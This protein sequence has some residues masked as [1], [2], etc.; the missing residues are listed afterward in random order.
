MIHQNIS[1]IVSVHCYVGPYFQKREITPNTTPDTISDS[2][3]VTT[4][5]LRLNAVRALS[6]YLFKNVF[7]FGHRVRDFEGGIQ[8]QQNNFRF[9]CA[10]TKLYIS[11]LRNRR[12]IYL[13]KSLYKFEYT[14]YCSK[15]IK[16]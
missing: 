15:M 7:V 8:L 13:E 6:K 5:G 12:K 2:T 10:G 4:R 9:Y 14:P 11:A 16:N 3:S 1:T